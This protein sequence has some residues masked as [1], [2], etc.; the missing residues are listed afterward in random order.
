MNRAVFINVTFDAVTSFNLTVASTSTLPLLIYGSH[1]MTYPLVY[2]LTNLTFVNNIACNSQKKKF[3]LRFALNVNKDNNL[4]S[5]TVSY[6]TFWFS[7]ITVLNNI[8]Y[9]VIMLERGVYLNLANYSCVNNNNEQVTRGKNINQDFGACLD[10]INTRNATLSNISIVSCFS[11]MTTCGIKIYMESEK[12]RFSDFQE[13]VYFC[14]KAALI[15]K[16]I[17]MTNASF[18]NNTV[19]LTSVYKAGAALFV[20]S[21]VTLIVRINDSLFTVF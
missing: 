20:D 19:S 6:S 4:M 18:V 17:N 15:L 3:S 8:C 14:M 11:R 16:Q 1:S 13:V 5:V 21:E 2:N 10:L 7:N 12:N 9:T